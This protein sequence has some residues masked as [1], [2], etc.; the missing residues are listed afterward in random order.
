MNIRDALQNK[1]VST[2]ETE[3]QKSVTNIV[4][5][6][7]LFLLITFP[8]LNNWKFMFHWKKRCVVTLKASQTPQKLFF[9]L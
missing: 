3:V 4:F 1:L 8:S 7:L 5:F 2:T 9:F 6:N